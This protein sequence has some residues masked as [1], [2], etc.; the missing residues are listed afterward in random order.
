MSVKHLATILSLLIVIQA[1]SSCSGNGT[2]SNGSAN[3]NAANTAGN[4]ARTVNDNA[5]ELGLLVLLP[6]QPV[7]VA[8]R[9]DSKGKLIAVMRFEPKDAATIAEQAAKFKPPV[10]GTVEV[11]DWFPK[12]LA[13]QGEMAEDAKLKGQ[14][15]PGDIMLQ[16]PYIRGR[17]LR[18]ENSDY[19]ILEAFKNN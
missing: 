5:E 14:E 9:E 7:E 17:L 19:Y 15:F 6:A 1:C 13:A 16:P 12:E 2:A 4:A 3:T 8:W 11:E 10:D 18:V